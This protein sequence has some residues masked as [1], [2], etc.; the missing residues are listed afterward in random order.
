[1]PLKR[2]QYEEGCLFPP[3]PSALHPRSRRRQRPGPARPHQLHAAH[4]PRRS[5]V[6][7]FDPHAGA[8]ADQVGASVD[9]LGRHPPPL[10]ATERL[11]NVIARNSCGW[12]AANGGDS[13][14]SALTAS[15]NDSLTLPQPYLT[16]SANV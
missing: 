10:R 2:R 13:V 16:R 14:V 15:P 4:R 11:G 1:M 7:A 12:P 3:A 9:V 6:A 8:E 5:A